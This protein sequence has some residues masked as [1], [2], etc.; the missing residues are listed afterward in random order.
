[1][2]VHQPLDKRVFTTETELSYQF[3]ILYIVLVVSL[4]LLDNDLIK[5][6]TSNTF[7]CLTL[8]QQDNLLDTDIFLLMIRVEHFDIFLLMIRVEHFEF[9]MSN[10]NRSAISYYPPR[11]V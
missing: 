3:L 9:M 11:D 6:L 1:M 7:E 5:T 2:T 4:L 10:D 8:S